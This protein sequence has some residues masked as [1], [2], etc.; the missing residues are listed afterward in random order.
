MYNP[1]AQPAR[2]KNK[3]ALSPVGLRLLYVFISFI[4]RKFKD[5]IKMLE[6]EIV[7]FF[8]SHSISKSHVSK[9]ACVVVILICLPGSQEC[10]AFSFAELE[11]KPLDGRNLFFDMF[12]NKAI[13]VGHGEILFF[14]VHQSIVKRF[15]EGSLG[16]ES[17]I[18][19]CDEHSTEV[20]R[21]KT[22]RSTDNKKNEF[23]P[24]WFSYLLW[25]A[26]WIPDEVYVLIGAIIGFIIA[27]RF[28]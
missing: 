5:F 13:G 18:S 20:S 24:S 23:I 14:D 17:P 19:L 25:F 28:I 15:V 7:R 12:Y 16:V 6:R 11:L 8:A 22:D 4:V 26:H 3:P 27:L 21:D 1:L 2:T 9:F 10:S